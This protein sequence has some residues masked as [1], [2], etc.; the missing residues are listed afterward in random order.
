MMYKSFSAY[1]GVFSS[2][3]LLSTPAQAATV[4]WDQIEPSTNFGVPVINGG[5]VGTVVQGHTGSVTNQQRSPWENT[6]KPG[7][8]Y[9]YIR[10][11]SSAQWNLDAGGFDALSLMWGSLDSWNTIEF[12][13]FD[14]AT[15]TQ[16][17]TLLG[18]DAQFAGAPTTT[19]FINATIT[20]DSLFNQ[21]KFSSG[22]N[23]FEFTNMQVSNMPS[24]AT[25]P[26]FF[27]GSAVMALR[28]R[29]R[30]TAAAV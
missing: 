1:V 29:H 11:D 7:E 27:V 19:D 28:R 2:I 3:V 17:D 13:F 25:L 4:I 24:P 8:T 12:F 23:S 30:K 10:G 9:T 16:A 18:S 20:T 14:G 15:Q 5:T 22:L 6:T 26:L 21:V